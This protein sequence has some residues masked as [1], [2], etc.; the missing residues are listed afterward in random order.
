MSYGWSKVKRIRRRQ[1]SRSAFHKRFKKC[2]RNRRNG[3]SSQT[4]F[5]RCA[6][7]AARSAR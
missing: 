7:I 5:K 1:V 6:K 2:M 3:K 4:R